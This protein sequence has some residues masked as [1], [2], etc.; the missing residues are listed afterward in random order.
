M[1]LAVALASDGARV[2][3]T[4]LDL[5][6]RST[7]S[8]F[9]NRKAWAAASHV[10][11]AMPTLI[12]DP[13]DPLALEAALGGEVDFHIIDTPGADSE[14]SRAAHRRADVIVT[15][16]NDSFVDFGMLGLIDPVSLELTRPSLYAETV[17]EA[18]KQRALSENRSIDWIVLRNRLAPVEAR[19]RRRIDERLE[20]LSKRV[21]FRIADGLRE[22]VIWRELYPFGLTVADLCAE[23]RPLKISLSHIAARQALRVLAS[24]LG[25][26]APARPLT[27]A[28]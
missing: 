18:R 8:F 4:D 7:A 3:V 6:Q 10:A 19:N 26:T 24:D 9:S 20:A 16:M 25:L 1:H 12:A 11:L 15:P 2:A 13:T 22:R 21:G 23:V 27:A 14:L 5:R 17:W 28:A